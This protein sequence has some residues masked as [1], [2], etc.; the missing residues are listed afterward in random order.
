M[1]AGRASRYASS[2]NVGACDTGGALKRPRTVTD[3]SGHVAPAG[4]R[5][6]KILFCWANVTGYMAA[7][8]RQLQAHE[9]IDVAVIARAPDA[10]HNNAP[11]DIDLMHG[12]EGRLLHPQHEHDW[13]IIR[14]EVRRKPSAAGRARHKRM[15][16]PRVSE[17]VN[18]SRAS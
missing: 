14:D 10:T 15:G 1:R 8:W 7:C 6:T 9:D 4:G 11:F 18:C 5:P 17:T 3:A 12:V 16:Q 2:P 13:R